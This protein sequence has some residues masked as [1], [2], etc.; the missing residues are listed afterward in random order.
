MGRQPWITTPIVKKYGGPT[1]LSLVSVA[2]GVNLSQRT[3]T[4]ALELL[5]LSIQFYI[6]PTLCCYCTI[7]SL[8]V[9]WEWGDWGAKPIEPICRAP[10]CQ[11]PLSSGR[12]GDLKLVA[13]AFQ[14]T[15]HG[16][17]IVRFWVQHRTIKVAKTQVYG[18]L[19]CGVQWG[20]PSLRSKCSNKAFTRT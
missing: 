5:H 2:K 11:G 6:A 7:K 1:S 16:I 4:S 19:P 20:N 10:L 8:L 15:P 17:C 9:H 18:K 13:L 14:P 12:C 3:L